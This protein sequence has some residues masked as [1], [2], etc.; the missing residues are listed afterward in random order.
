VIDIESKDKMTKTDE[1]R[2]TP[3]YELGPA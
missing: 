2:L 1:E 3:I